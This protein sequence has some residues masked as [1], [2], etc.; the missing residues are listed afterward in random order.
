M[1]RQRITLPIEDFDC[2]GSSAILIEQ[3]LAEVPG[4]LHIYVSAAMEMAYVQ[5]DAEICSVDA[6]REAVTFAGFKIG[7]TIVP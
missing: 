5:Y 6:L 2:A 3:A 7:T 1:D 4:V